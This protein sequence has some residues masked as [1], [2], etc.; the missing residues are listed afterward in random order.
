MD[1]LACPFCGHAPRR[2]DYEDFSGFGETWAVFCDD[3][4]ISGPAM[5]NEQDAVNAWNK[6][7]TVSA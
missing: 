3:C 7:V 5:T 4:G 1:L 2:G 6:R